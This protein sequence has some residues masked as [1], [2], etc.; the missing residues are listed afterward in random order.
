M[1]S[2]VNTNGTAGPADQLREI[3]G[4][5]EELLGS[6]GDGGDAAVAQLRQRVQ[7]TI[8]DAKV[9]LGNL[10][11]QARDMADK[12]VTG[13]DSYVRGNPWIAVGVAAAIGAMLGALVSRRI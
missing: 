7:S 12:A 1:E 10:Q 4:K 11:T 3:V 8:Q 5:A 2:T 9:K 13:T 6:L